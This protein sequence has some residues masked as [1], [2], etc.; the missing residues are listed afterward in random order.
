MLEHHTPG[1]SSY[2]ET[3]IVP[4]GVA[5]DYWRE[6]WRHRELLQMLT[7]RDL[8]IRYKQTVMGVGWALVRPL[9]TMVIL[10]TIFGR[11]AKL[12]SEGAPY[13]LMVLAGLLPWTFFASALSDASNS[14]IANAGLITK[15]Y[16]PRMLVPASTVLAAVADFVV[17]L[18]LLGVVMAWYQVPP[19]WRMLSLPV[20][21][22]L[23]FCAALGPGLWLTAMSVKFRDFKYVIPFVLQIAL[24]VSPIGFSSSL[25][26]D[27]WRAV[28]ALN[29][30]VGLVD[31]FRWSIGVSR[32]LYWTGLAIST[33]VIVLSCWLG[34][35]KFRRT[36]ALIAD[37]V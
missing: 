34:I 2:G 26:P 1:R 35:R 18:L 27:R 20:F 7:W 31:G 28:F 14:L 15:V 8:S 37:L 11:L 5:S 19:T 17:A 10:T 23:A 22:A 29:P 30:L 16:F 6:L 36:E 12:P 25:V 13:A 9:V 21:G 4:G 3:L 32:D 33:A 24:Y